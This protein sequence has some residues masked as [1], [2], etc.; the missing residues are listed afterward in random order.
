MNSSKIKLLFLK[1]FSLLL[2]IRIA[3]I[4]I[5]IIS[6]YISAIFLFNPTLEIKESLKNLKLHGIIISSALSVS[7]GY[8]INQFYDQD[9]DAIYR[10]IWVNM[11][12]FINTKTFLKIYLLLNIISLLIA[13][14][15]SYKIFIFFLVYQFLIWFYSHKLSRILII[16]NI[17]YSILT[18]FPFFAL[19]LFY[20]NYSPFILLLAIQLFI[21]LIIKELYKDL[22]SYKADFIFSYQTLPNTLGIKGTKICISLLLFFLLLI[23]IKLAVSPELKEIRLYYLLTGLLS[24]LGIFGIYLLNKSYNQL[25]VLLIKF[26]IFIGA[27]SLLFI[28]GNPLPL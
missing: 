3:N 11:Q 8:I 4:C 7:A 13:F 1:N 23:S 12:Q 20:E 15:L 10:P 18:I 9:K 24:L 19:F 28:E 25:I 2:Q 16:N 26:W 17:S 5:L 27:I 6:M 21:L 22:I 14:F